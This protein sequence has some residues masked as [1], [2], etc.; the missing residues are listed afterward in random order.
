M[1]RY[2]AVF[3]ILA[4]PVRACELALLLAVDVSGSVDKNEYRVQMDGLALALRDGIVADALVDQRAHVSLVQ[5]TGSTRQ[6]QT[7]PWT[8]ILTH[9]DVLALADIIADDPRVW[10]NYSTAIG[11]AL[12]ISRAAFAPVRHCARK[13]IDV[14][15]DGVSNEGIEPATQRAA[16]N[17]DGIIV[18]ALAI[19]TDQTD[20]TAYFFENLITGPGAFVVTANGFADYPA[21]IKRKLQRETTR[22]VTLLEDR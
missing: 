14:S 18:N 5:W 12:S 13:V 17:A 8:E 16:L 6:R 2:L 19:E 20:L 22:Q 7:V 1:L 9:R 11:E 21:Q 4:A 3:L 15:G 10:R